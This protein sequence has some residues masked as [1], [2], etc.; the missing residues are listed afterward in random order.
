METDQSIEDRRSRFGK[1]LMAIPLVAACTIVC[2]QIASGPVL[3]QTYYARI[4]LAGISRSDATRGTWRVGAWS[5][6]ICFGGSGIQTRSVTCSGSSCD[7]GSMPTSQQS[8]GSCAYSCTALA[9]NRLFEGTSPVYLGEYDNASKAQSSCAGYAASTKLDG[10][11]NWNNVRFS[12][13]YRKL[14]YLQGS[15]TPNEFGNQNHY[16]TACSWK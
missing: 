6:K 8:A 14:Y 3:A 11:C 10:G 7:A 16:A 9:A 2:A 13:G 5:E 12:A 4:P 1:R 15:Q